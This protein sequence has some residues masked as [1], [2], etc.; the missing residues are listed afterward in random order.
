MVVPVSGGSY[1]A[2]RIFAAYFAKQGMA[3]VIVHRPKL[4]GDV[5][6]LDELNTMLKQT[7]KDHIQVLDW[8]VTQPSLDTNR[9]A[10]FGASLGGIKGALLTA[11]DGRIKAAALGLAGS[12]LPYIVTHSTERGV[13]RARTA[14]LQ[15]QHWTLPELEQR[16]RDNIT[17]DPQTLAP[18]V[19]S[20][21]VLLILGVF[22]SVVPFKKGWELR[23]HLGKPETI[24]LPSGHYTA[25]LFIPYL[26]YATLT[27]FKQRFK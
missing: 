24:L 18:Y 9:V 14:V 2:E 25:A 27:F 8:L 11:L 21:K 1:Q 6:S 19:D 26:E 5:E 3:A 22:D 13:V 15:K 7:V 10:L 23:K 20:R 16:L 12:D 17:L 4:S